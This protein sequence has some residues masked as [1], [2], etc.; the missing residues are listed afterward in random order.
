MIGIV[1]HDEY[2]KYTYNPDTDLLRVYTHSAK[3]NY[4][5][6]VM[7]NIYFDYDDETDEF[8]GLVVYAFSKCNLHEVIDYAKSQVD[9]KGIISK[10]QC[11]QY[12]N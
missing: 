2:P 11:G 10:I 1:N 9:L 7:P 12:K 5:E 8:I 6:E 4:Y 3:A